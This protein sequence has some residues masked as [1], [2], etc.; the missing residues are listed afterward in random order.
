[1]LSSK[2]GKVSWA[3][4]VTERRTETILSQKVTI[5]Q[6]LSKLKSLITITNTTAV[7]V[8]LVA[9][10]GFL[11]SSCRVPETVEQVGKPLLTASLGTQSL[12]SQQR[13]VEQPHPAEKSQWDFRDVCG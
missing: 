9:F 10:C 5:T 11:N 1:M 6:P 13:A 8:A 12:M 3:F 2:V 4:E 7:H